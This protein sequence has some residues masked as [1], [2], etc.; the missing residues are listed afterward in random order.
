[1][2]FINLNGCDIINHLIESEVINLQDIDF[3]QL[4]LKSLDKL[5]AKCPADKREEL[6]SKFGE[7]FFT[8]ASL[9]CKQMLEEYHN[10]LKKSSSTDKDH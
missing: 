3:E 9:V 5:I 8:L 1:M 7:Q 10:S 6:S 2:D 4:R